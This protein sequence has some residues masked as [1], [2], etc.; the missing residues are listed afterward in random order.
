VLF[1]AN[2]AYVRD[3]HIIVPADCVGAVNEGQTRFALRYFRTVLKADVRVSSRLPLKRVRGVA[4][5]DRPRDQHH[6][7]PS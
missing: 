7:A 4:R 2:D 1:T 5:Q 6:H 3:L